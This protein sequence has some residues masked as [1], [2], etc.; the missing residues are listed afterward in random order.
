MI[1]DLFFV[2]EDAVAYVAVI[3]PQW[4]AYGLPR[5]VTAFQIHDFGSY[6]AEIGSDRIAPIID[7]VVMSQLQFDTGI[8]HYAGILHRSADSHHVG[9]WKLQ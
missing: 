2:L 4:V 9:N 1:L 5:C 6:I 7:T 8:T 3:C